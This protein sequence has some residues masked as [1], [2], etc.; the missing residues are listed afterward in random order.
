MEVGGAIAVAMEGGI[1]EWSDG[2]A[3]LALIRE[4][5]QGTERGKMIGNGCHYTGKK[6]GV[7]RIPT[8]KRQCLSGYDPRILKGTGVTYATSTMGADHTCGNALPNPTNPDYNPS[9]A[10]GQAPV[11]Q[12]LQYYFAAV[13]T[14]GMCLFAMLPPLDMPELQDAISVCAA[15]V[16]GSNLDDKYLMKLGE[17]VLRIE[18][19]FNNK[20][21]L[22]TMEDRLP[23]FFSKEPL[24]PSGEVFDV[25]EEELDSVHI[26]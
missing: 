17:Q 4:I 1:L 3:A 7:S 25:T 22:D 6:L 9:S 20:A 23:S 19:Q 13:D 2:K 15:A 21:G 12:F 24:V 18:K 8:V 26:L 10:T 16:Q 11:S 14:L 5:A